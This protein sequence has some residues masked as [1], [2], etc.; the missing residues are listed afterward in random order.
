MN[1][2]KKITKI[3]NFDHI[4]NFELRNNDQGRTRGQS[5]FL[6][7]DESLYGV[8]DVEFKL[9]KILDEN[10]KVFQRNDNVYIKYA[11]GPPWIDL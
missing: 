4:R 9:V 7:L 6:E 5:S 11:V 10:F 2:T 3:R 8:Y 1:I